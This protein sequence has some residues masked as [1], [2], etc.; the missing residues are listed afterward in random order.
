MKFIYKRIFLALGLFAVA[1]FFSGYLIYKTYE[2]LGEDLVRR[3]ALLMGASVS[4]V[5][6]NAAD[7]NLESLTRSEKNAVRRLM[8]SL[9]SEEG[10]II[11]ILLINDKMR[12]LLS[13]DRNVE[14]RE[15]TSP[16]ELANL[17][18]DQPKVIT[19]TWSDSI[20]VVDVILPLKG[21]QDYV[22]GYLR[23]VL[24]QRGILTFFSDFSEIFIPLAIVIAL[25]ISFTIFFIARAYSKPLESIELMAENLTAGDFNYRINYERKDEFTD[26]FTRINKSLEKVSVLSESYKK[27]EKRIHALLQVV[28]ES[29]IL[30]DQKK[31]IT[32]Y[33]DAAIELFQCPV[34]TD[35]ERHFGKIQTINPELKK[36][37]LN[38]FQNEE[39]IH[40]KEMILWMPDGSDVLARVSTFVF[41]E[42]GKLNGVLFTIKD[43][44]LINELQR[45][46]QRSMKFGVIANLASSISHE[47]KNPLSSMAIHIEILNVRLKEFDLQNKDVLDKSLNVLQNEVKRLNRIISQFFNLAR[48]KKTDLSLISINT[49]LEEVLTLVSQ[50]AIERNIK[51][52]T[53]LEEN[54]EKVYGDPD[55]LK[56]V[57]LNIILNAFQ[58]I[59]HEGITRIRTMQKSK[60]IVIDI[61]DNGSGMP[62]DVQERLFELYFTTKHDGGGIGMSICK[63]IIE[64][65]E[66]NITFESL[67]DKG[68][69]FHIE[70]P[71]KDHTKT[72][73]AMA[74]K[75]VSETEKQD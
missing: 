43:Q 16:E 1:I 45:N 3:T 53:Q 58:A 29:I 27:A 33:N 63:N 38:V 49:I 75:S 30:L 56:Q 20:Q 11:H 32:S 64:A 21:E 40:A 14:G 13:S 70:L 61:E 60:N 9:T 8:R 2:N 73:K 59:H 68:T 35:F 41:K 28:E 67:V 62:A 6:A 23:L 18:G 5:L 22:Y 74:R 10:N 52:E 36:L 31:R 55:Q 69:T 57:F 4:E 66:G 25:L 7:K 26:T 72:L 71:R 48:I 17:Q 19:K 46:L 39:N 15:Y 47:L 34:Q 42:D 65:H 24:S 12:I 54:L 44:K 37:V 50:Q 51:I